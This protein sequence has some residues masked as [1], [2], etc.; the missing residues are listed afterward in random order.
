MAP[1]KCGAIC[2]R[3]KVFASGNECGELY[4]LRAT[5]L[6]ADV[7]NVAVANVRFSPRH[8]QSVDL[9]EQASEQRVGSGK[10]DGSD[11]RHFHSQVM[12]GGNGRLNGLGVI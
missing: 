9:R 10:G 6:K 1:Q 12:R 11:L 7:R 4:P 8:Q 3:W 2:E 5:A